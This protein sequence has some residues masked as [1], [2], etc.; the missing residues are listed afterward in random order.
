MFPLPSTIWLK[1]GAAAALCVFMYFM[2]WNHE[3]KKFV[4]FQAEIA[5]LGK[6]QESLN[7]AK[8]KKHE[9]ITNGIKDE[10]EARLAAVHNYYSKRVQQPNA[11][12]NR[13]PTVSKPTAC[14]VS[15]TTDTELVE[16]CARTTL[17]LT[18][19]QKWVKGI[20]NAK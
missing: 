7:Q 5:A 2:G 11:S 16:R 4:N 17:Q 12:T 18:E 13:L 10:Y 19:L 9:I 1:I 15:A 8:V 20:T 6:A 3:H 14:P